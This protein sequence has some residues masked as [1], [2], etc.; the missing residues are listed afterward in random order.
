MIKVGKWNYKT[1]TYDDYTLPC[2]ASLWS[3]DLEKMIRC[4]SCAKDI[5]S[6]DCY[7][8]L[9]IHSDLGM[10]FLV[11]PCCYEEEVERRK[12]EKK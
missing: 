9:E 7:T 3:D 10:G 1:R 8:S 11:C 4:A 5:K 2:G 12:K 6:G